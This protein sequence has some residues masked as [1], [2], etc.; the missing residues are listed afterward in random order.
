MYCEV[1]DHSRVWPSWP[2]RWPDADVP[3]SAKALAFS[4]F[5]NTGQI[6]QALSRVYVHER[7]VKQ[8]AEL[9][10]KEWQSMATLGDPSTPSTTQGP[11]ADAIQYKRVMEYI[12]IGQRDG[13][14]TF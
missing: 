8:F 4:I 1:L 5:R 14:L 13:K 12:E 9:Y 6:C 11:V 10:Q 3:K 2:S 7:I